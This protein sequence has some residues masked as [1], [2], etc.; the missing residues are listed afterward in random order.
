M[1]ETKEILKFKGYKGPNNLSDIINWLHSYGIFIEV[2][3]RWNQD[4]TLMQGYFGKVWL[5]PYE[6][7]WIGP[8]CITFSAAIDTVISKVL[9]F[10]PDSK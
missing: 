2:G 4:G 10:L 5:P 7:M 1:S 9:D 3:V 8:P 6:N